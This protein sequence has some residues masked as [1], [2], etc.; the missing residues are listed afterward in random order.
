MFF[1]VFQKIV[2]E[3]KLPNSFYEASITLIPKLEKEIT[4]KENYKPIP[5]MNIDTKFFNKILANQIQ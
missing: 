4:K 5:P 3:G 1:N 2:Q